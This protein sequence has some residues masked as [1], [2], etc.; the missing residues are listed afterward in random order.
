M[1]GGKTARNQVRG[2][3]GLEKRGATAGDYRL[4]DTVSGGETM[5]SLGL[6]G[7]ALCLA[8]V[9]AL[10]TPSLAQEVE[11]RLRQGFDSNVFE[12]GAAAALE[13][14]DAYYTLVGFAFKSPRYGKRTSFRVRPEGYFKWYPET[15]GGNQF[16]G[17]LSLELRNVSK[18]RRFGKRRKTTVSLAATGE[19]ERALFIKRSVREELRV[20]G[21]DPNVAFA[22]LPSRAE[23]RGELAVRAAVSSVVTLEG[24]VLGRMRDYSPSANPSLPDY[25]RLDSREFGGWAGMYTEIA[26]DWELGV[27]GM[28][29]ARVYPNRNARTAD[30]VSV[31][32]EDRRFWYWDVAASLAFK[33]GGVRNKAHVSYVRRSDQFEGYYSYDGWEVGD[34]I[35]LP[36]GTLFDLR[37]QYDYGQRQYDLFAPAGS[38]TL[39]KYH[40]ARAEI[41]AHLPGSVRLAFGPRYERTISND[42]VFDYERLDAF[43]EFRIKR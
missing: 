34:R 22:D 2:K 10:A 1:A 6:T 9:A 27:N 28:W 4:A 42:P 37:L 39:N 43:A 7:T 8:S 15:T 25:D 36:V 11:L 5:R 13:P 20:A 14:T 31:P 24:G 19:Y 16:G 41:I 35:T 21:I 3:R 38:P 17:S 40:D 30:G 32:G 12:V 26:E 18:Q 29:R 23:A 33:G